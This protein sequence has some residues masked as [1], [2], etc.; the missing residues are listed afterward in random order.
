MNFDVNTIHGLFK[1]NRLLLYK[2][3]LAR[4]GH[5]AQSEFFWSSVWYK[6]Y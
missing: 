3:I 2:M 1:I 4:M 6:I 5:G